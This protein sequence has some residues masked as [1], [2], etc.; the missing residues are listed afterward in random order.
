MPPM[1]NLI[2]Q[3]NKRVLLDIAVDDLNLS[4]LHLA[5]SSHNQKNYLAKH[6]P[7]VEKSQIIS[8]LHDGVTELLA[9]DSSTV[10]VLGL[11]VDL[12]ANI[13]SKTELHKEH[14]LLRGNLDE[15]IDSS[16]IYA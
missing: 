10:G 15:E 12:P 2:S 7:G 1:G 5:P 11:S 4:R 6:C 9:A 14:L 8:V 16:P 13:E 3:L